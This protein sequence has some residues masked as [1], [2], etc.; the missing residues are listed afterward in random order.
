MPKRIDEINIFRTVI[1]QLVS[2]EYHGT[3]TKEIAKLTGINEATLFR[4]YGNKPG[5]IKR[6]LEHQF[7]TAPLSKVYYTGDLQA[8]L[9]SIL[10]AYVATNDAFGEIMPTVLLEIPRHP[11]LSNILK[12]ALANIQKLV[13]IIVRYQ[14]EGLLKKEPPQISI[15]VLLAPIL[16]NKMFHRADID[17]PLPS[18]NLHDYIETFLNGRQLN[19]PL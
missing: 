6:A 14:K 13:E 1:K 7:S 8:D 4:K 16:L 2:L 15:N 17:M 12:T 18:I 19:N 3:T 9:Y 5:L 10:E 11:E